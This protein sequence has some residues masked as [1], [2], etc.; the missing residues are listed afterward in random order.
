MKLEE[1]IELLNSDGTEEA[2]LLINIIP[3][4]QN[5]RPLTDDDMI[6][7]PLELLDEPFK[8]LPYSSNRLEVLNSQDGEE[9][10]GEGQ[11]T[12]TESHIPELYQKLLKLE[13]ETELLRDINRALTEENIHLKTKLKE[14]EAETHFSK[15]L[16]SP[17]KL[18]VNQ[19]ISPASKDS[20]TVC[21]SRVSCDAEFAKALKSFYQKMNVIRGQFLKLQHYR[22]P[23]EDNIQLL[24]LF[25]ERQSHLLKDFGEQLESSISKLKND[26]ALI[27]KKKRE[28]R[29]QKGIK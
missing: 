5:G 17:S 6:I 28:A 26:V 21:G 9:P 23:D 18:Q 25:T 12:D 4:M 7:D 16:K 14:Y 8:I 10:Y 29:L 19:I 1:Q 2:I 13:Q 11:P 3:C 22:A 24:R 27:V 20:R 15:I